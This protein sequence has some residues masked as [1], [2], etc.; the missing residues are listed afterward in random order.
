MPF[1]DGKVL[2]I[3]MVTGCHWF[4]QVNHVDHSLVVF[5][6]DSRRYLGESRISQERLKVLSGLGSGHSGNELG[7]TLRFL[8]T[9]C[10]QLGFSV[11]RVGTAWWDQTTILISFPVSH[12]NFKVTGDLSQL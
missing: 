9:A 3:D 7:L 11:G 12:I 1:L 8:I 6:Q 10:R 2:N 4:A 5:I